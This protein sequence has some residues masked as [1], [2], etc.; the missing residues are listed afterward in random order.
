M[1]AISA[2][3]G[4]ILSHKELTASPKSSYF[5]STSFRTGREDLLGFESCAIV[6]L[7]FL[8]LFKFTRV[9]VVILYVAACS[10]CIKLTG[11]KVLHKIINCCLVTRRIQVQFLRLS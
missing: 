1:L 3:I 9:F 11:D 5:C 2:Y 6:F 4:A 10:V 7:I 8:N